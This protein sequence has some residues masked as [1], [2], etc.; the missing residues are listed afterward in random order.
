LC[1]THALD[2][3]AVVLR[4]ANVYGRGMA[5]NNVVSTVL[6][7]IPGRGPLKVMDEA[8]QRDFLWI[9]D[10]AEALASAA[11]RAAGPAILNI[12]TGVATSI[13]K[14]A[15]LA[16]RLAAEPERAVLSSKP[17]GARSCLVLDPSAARAKLGWQAATTLESG[18]S[19]LLGK[20]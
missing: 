18:L 14:L 20:P 12:S 17:S 10:L 6:A 3:G 8:P 13:G 11:L 7:Q 19:L 16:L 15:R 9:G 1:E 2:R 4:V 5:A